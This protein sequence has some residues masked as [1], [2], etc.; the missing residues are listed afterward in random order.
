MVGG[1][2]VT[3]AR[4]DYVTG[5]GKIIIFTVSCKLKLVIGNLA[6]TY[7]KLFVINTN[8][9]YTGSGVNGIL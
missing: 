9:V 1:R 8:S 3:R 5:M 6:K 7:G 4:N 2:K